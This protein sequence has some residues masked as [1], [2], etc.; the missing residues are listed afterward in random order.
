MQV[1]AAKTPLSKKSKER[2]FNSASVP[3]EKCI[4]CKIVNKELPSH[5]I[6]EDNEY[7]AFLDNHPFNEGHTLVCPK[8]HG[9]TVWDMSQE[10]I[11]GLFMLASRVSK[12]LVKATG[13]DGFRFVQNNG[14]AAN[15]IVP[16]VHVHTIPVR[17]S[18]KG[19]WLDRKKLP[20][21]DM[22]RIAQSIKGFIE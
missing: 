10:E 6:F 11:G 16:H 3:P 8:K 4:F 12:A 20:P 13:A 21:E 22:E 15:Q 18:D 1:T 7:I 2:L 19:K 9:E 14:E 17:L 5:V